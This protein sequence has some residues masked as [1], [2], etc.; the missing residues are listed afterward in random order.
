[1]IVTTVP[2]HFTKK[3]EPGRIGG[4]GGVIGWEPVMPNAVFIEAEVEGDGLVSASQHGQAGFPAPAVYVRLKETM[5]QSPVGRGREDIP[6]PGGAV[7]KP[8]PCDQLVQEHWIVQVWGERPR[9]LFP[10]QFPLFTGKGIPSGTPLA[11][12]FCQSWEPFYQ[13]DGGREG[14]DPAGRIPGDGMGH[15]VIEF[16]GFQTGRGKD[17]GWRQE[18]QT[19]SDHALVVN[20]MSAGG[21]G[22]FP[23]CPLEGQKTAYV[24]VFSENQH[25][26]IAIYVLHGVDPTRTK[27]R[28]EQTGAGT[29]AFPT[30]SITGYIRPGGQLDSSGHA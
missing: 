3:K 9:S 6:D 22:G 30:V 12:E 8:L 18:G 7:L 11:P 24:P 28:V 20:K 1:M 16:Q 29:K 15:S 23:A 17:L 14:G 4:P 25:F 10:D 21:S 2:D 27:K 19:G 5:E 26:D 13:A